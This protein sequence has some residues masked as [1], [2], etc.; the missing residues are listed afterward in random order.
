MSNNG[1]FIKHFPVTLF[2]VS[3]QTFIALNTGQH[4]SNLSTLVNHFD[5]YVLG[6]V[7]ARRPIDRA[8]IILRQ[9]CDRTAS[10]VDTSQ[11]SYFLSSCFQISVKIMSLYTLKIS[12]IETYVVCSVHCTGQGNNIRRM[13]IIS[14]DFCPN[15]NTPPNEVQ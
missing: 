14:E 2:R 3:F 1:F 12:A 9:P 8:L 15:D 7:L 10:R 6:P 13:P 11:N 4:W 5:K